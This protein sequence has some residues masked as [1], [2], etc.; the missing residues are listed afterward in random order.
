[1]LR[2][3]IHSKMM[4][5]KSRRKPKSSQRIRQLQKEALPVDL[6][7]TV[8][9]KRLSVVH[10]KTRTKMTTKKMILRTKKSSPTFSR[11]IRKETTAF[12][13]GA[14]PTAQTKLKQQ[15]YPSGKNSQIKI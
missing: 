1:M 3:L 9:S 10:L 15:V 11:L 13:W 8:A 2:F 4:S 14:L 6:N 5:R 7:R 12:Q